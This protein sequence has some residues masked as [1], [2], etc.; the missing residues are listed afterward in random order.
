L[1]KQRN[2]ILSVSIVNFGVNGV[3]KVRIKTII[4]KISVH[5]NIIISVTIGTSVSSLNGRGE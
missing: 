2:P 1:T 4:A 5:L 3:L